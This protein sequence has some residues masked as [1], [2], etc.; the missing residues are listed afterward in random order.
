MG[1]KNLKA[2]AVRGTVGFKEDNSEAFMKVAGAANKVLHGSGARRGLMRYGTHSMLDSMQEF[3]GL[4]TRNFC[5]VSLFTA[6]PFFTTGS[7]IFLWSFLESSV[8]SVEEISSSLVNC[9]E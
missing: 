7:S 6:N 1:S 5:R 8:Y 3:G 9:L 2:I 4:P